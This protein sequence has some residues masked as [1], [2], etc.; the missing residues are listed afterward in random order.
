MEKV[1]KKETPNTGDRT[2]MMASGIMIIVLT[3]NA[4]LTIVLKNRKE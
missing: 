2:P 4:L 3:I 1:N